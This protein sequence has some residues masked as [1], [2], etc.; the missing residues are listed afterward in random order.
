MFLRIVLRKKSL[1]W[2]ALE[3]LEKTGSYK[4]QRTL[5]S[6][7]K[8]DSWTSFLNNGFQTNFLSQRATKKYKQ[9]LRKFTVLSPH[10]TKLLKNNLFS[11]HNETLRTA[12]Q[13]FQF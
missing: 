9:Q 2:E 5:Y 4:S 1:T 3:N 6:K 7:K 13:L 8:N 11:V 10:F 12:A